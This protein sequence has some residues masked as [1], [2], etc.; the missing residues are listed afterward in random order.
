VTQ[1]FGLPHNLAFRG[2]LRLLTTF[3]LPFLLIVPFSARAQMDEG[4]ITGI[5]QDKSGAAIPGATVTLTSTETGLTLQIKSGSSG[6]YTFPPLKV[7][8]YTVSAVS[9]GFGVTT[10]ENIRVDVQSRINVPLVLVPAGVSQTVTVTTAPP[11]L[12]TEQGSVGQVVSTQTINNIPLNSRNWVYVAQLAAGVAPGVGGRALGS[13]DF[14]ANG[15]RPE[16]NDFI[17]DGVDNNTGAADLLNGSS[18]VVAPPPDAL[19]EFNIQTSNFSA[20]FGHSAGAVLNATI[21]SGTNDIHGDLW[22]Y[23]RNTDLDARD[24]DAQTIP[25][26]HQNQFGA[27]L[28]APV[29]RNRL[30][31]FG[32][33][34]N[35]RIVFGETGTY[36]VPTAP[37]RQ[38]D[39][40]E[41]LNP[42]LTS[43]GKAVTLYEPGSAGTTPLACNGQVN[44][45]CSGSIDTVAQAVLNAYPLP[46]ANNGKLFN[47]YNVTSNAINNTFQWGTRFDWNIS[48]HDLAFVRFSYMNSPASYP[49]PLGATIDA[50]A[51]GADGQIINRGENF[52]FSETHIFS[53]SASNEFRVGYNYGDFRFLQ[54]EFNNQNLA[55][56][57][58]LGGIP[59]GPEIGGGLPFGN[60]TGLT[61]F[62][63]PQY[64]PNHK[65]ENIAQVLDNF[66]KVMGRHALKFGVQF[67]NERFPFYSPSGARGVYNYTGYFTSKPGVS[68]TG[69]GAA[70]FLQNQMN[71]ASINT[72]IQL[73]MSRWYRSAYVQDDWRVSRKL[74]VNLGLRY[75]HFQPLKE[76]GGHFA[77][78]YMVSNGPGAG[79]ASLTYPDSQ[80]NTY[81]APAFLAIL[82]SNN[83]PLQFTG[84]TS[85]VKPQFENFAP[86]VGAAYSFNDKTV[87]RAGYGIFYGGMENFGGSQ[88][89]ENY[90]FQFTS[91]YNRGS[92]CKPGNCVTNGI[93]LETGF[94][95]YLS[96]GLANT[97]S[98][99]SFAGSVPDVKT[100]YT[101]SYNLSVERALSQSLSLTLAYIGNQTRHLVVEE[102]RNGA[103]ALIDPRLNS[104]TAQP[105]PLLGGAG[106]E[107]YAG[108]SNY[109]GFQATGQKQFS[110]GLQ[111]L[112]SYTWS[113]S[114]DDA[115]D[116]LANA[117]SEGFRAYNLIGLRP[118]YTNSL[119][120]VRNRVAFNGFYQLPFGRNHRFL[121]RGAVLDL[122]TGDWATDL[123]FTAQSG[124]PISIKT[125][126]GSAAP[127]GGTAY[128]VRVGNPFASGGAPPASNSGISCAASTRNRMHW[129]NP[130]A[131]ANPPLAFPDAQVAGSP[132]STTQI[133]GLAALPYLGGRPDTIAGPG[134]ERV[135]MS[136]FKNFRTFREQ[137]LELRADVFNLL[138][139]PSLSYPS[140]SD[141]SSNGGE[142]TS[143]RAIQNLTPDARFFQLAAKY[144]F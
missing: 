19:S 88:E 64:Y 15:Q 3:A 1:S 78:F 32:Y 28:G 4:T 101:E 116:Q 26:Y 137:R 131:F 107:D 69:Y 56:S 50:G 51:Y 96:A 87:I 83:I 98:T 140:V 66:Q 27:T 72:A 2:F 126:L 125:D 130:C 102:A 71:S 112:A 86:R 81:L 42:A 16:Q 74:T 5:V 121:N 41:L 46:N 45:I 113:H 48:S 55:A 38:G 60:I 92:V 53:V 36:S 135:N 8:N 18:F 23:V 44:V 133:T 59:N 43:T 34:E 123:Q 21:K 39:F 35:N 54:S 124:S 58:G 63:Q 62:G 24:F 85:I 106:V 100:P 7:G 120:D 128:A 94:S 75:D 49:P 14:A 105:F 11:L 138:N 29:L 141:D 67:L 136:L 119:F 17:L 108:A 89:L 70:D 76:V 97:V 37:M 65:G 118:D 132:V 114:L 129:Y 73:D 33:A 90:P 80:K 25:A 22:E 57:M 6:T 139:T 30:F 104:T 68:N 110:N 61:T 93:T 109:N 77:N 127:N 122:L 10:Q 82:S 91:S 117:P 142:I 99:P 12:Q 40:T 13:G 47:N 103:A 79:S 84:V 95:Q 52:V 111:F 143:P 144:T 31:F 20:E 134:F 115:F 9:P